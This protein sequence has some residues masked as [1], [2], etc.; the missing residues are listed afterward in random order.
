MFIFSDAVIRIF[1][2]SP[3]RMASQMEIDTYEEQ[4]SASL[5]PAQIGDIKTE[6]LVGPEAL[7]VPGTH[8]LTSNNVL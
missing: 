6:D 1:T 8:W 5:I 7:L 3:D 4:L 2:A